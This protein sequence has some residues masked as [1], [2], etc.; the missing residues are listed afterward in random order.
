MLPKLRPWLA[1]SLLAPLLLPLLG[2]CSKE[3]P[4]QQAQAGKIQEINVSYQPALYWAFPF[5]VATEKNWWQEAGLKANFSTFPAGAPQVATLANK[6]W[7][8]GGTG[9]VPALLGA[10]RFKLL[11]VGIT[12]DESAA[13]V[14]MVRGDKAA[15]YQKD[16]ASMKGKQILLTTNSTGDYAV[17]A[18]LKKLGLTKA[19]VQM[20]NMGQAQIISAISSNNGELAGVWAPNTY[21]LEEKT[22][23]KVL[24]SGKDVGAEVPG[25]LVAREDFAKE[26]PEAVAKFLAVY[27]RAQKWARDNPAE[28]VKMMQAFYK[29]GGVELADKYLKEEFATRPT[30]DLAEQLKLMNRG[31]GGESTFDG[32][33]SKIGEFIKSVGTVSE[34]PV[35][36]TFVTDEYLKLVDKD[37]K[38]KAFANNKP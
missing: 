38:L 25:A 26:H 34:A 11:T 13:N 1:A 23:A 16:P 15:E 35:P 18:A 30:F 36:K 17:T 7:D 3:Q 28:A 21:T 2:S 4:K 29:Q 33:I 19:D 5:Y 6:A 10:A 14:L 31:A 20:V 12:N 8:V 37:P 24:F 27:L 22:G 9:S 32:W